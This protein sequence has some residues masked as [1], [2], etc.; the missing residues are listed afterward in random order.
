[1][2][3]LYAW[4]AA[5]GALLD[6]RPVH[7]GRL[8]WRTRNWDEAHF[9]GC[10]HHYGRYDEECLFPDFLCDLPPRR[11]LR[12]RIWFWRPQWHWHGWSTLLPW[13]TGGDEY[14]WHTVGFGW[15]VT[16]RVIIAT[17]HCP[18][19]G[20]CREDAELHGLREWDPNLYAEDE[21]S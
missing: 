20:K 10:P 9:P 11:P 12:S 13:F 7:A 17:R 1:M 4:K 6:G 14:D 18:A 5:G 16:G 15:T 8:W 19:T 3:S 21:T 2:I